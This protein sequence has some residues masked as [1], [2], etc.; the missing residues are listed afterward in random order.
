MRRV[1]LEWA[2]TVRRLGHW[3]ALHRCEAI[4]AAGTQCLHA[5][6]Y[7]CPDCGALRCG[8][9]NAWFWHEAGIPGPHCPACKATSR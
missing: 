2:P 6:T 7:I 1:A 8:N 9:H 3:I 4:T 5:G